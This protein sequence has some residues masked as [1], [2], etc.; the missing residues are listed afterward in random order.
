MAVMSGLPLNVAIIIFG[1]IF[2]M[3]LRDYRAR[4]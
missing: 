2:L 1:C 4:G 3:L